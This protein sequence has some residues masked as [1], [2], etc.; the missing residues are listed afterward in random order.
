MSVSESMTIASI[1]EYYTFKDILAIGKQI[2][3]IGLGKGK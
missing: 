2:R 3:I 1:L